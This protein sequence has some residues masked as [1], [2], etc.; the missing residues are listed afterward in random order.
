MKKNPR[1]SYNGFS[2][3]RIGPLTAGTADVEGSGIFCD[4]DVAA[5]TGTAGMAVVCNG[6]GADLFSASFAGAAATLVETL[7]VVSSSAVG[8]DFV[9]VGAGETGGAV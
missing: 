3:E 5:A 1:S 8:I 4:T 7:R 2:T 6:A 9:D